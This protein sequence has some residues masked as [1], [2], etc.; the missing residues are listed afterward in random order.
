MHLQVEFSKQ[1]LYIMFKEVRRQEALLNDTETIE[2]LLFTAKY[3]FLSVGQTENGYAYGVPISF[4]WNKE[5]NK[6]YF[7]G[8]AN[9]QKLD[10][11][12]ENSKISFCVVGDINVIP[13]RFTTAYESVIAFGTAKI[14]LTDEEK[15]EAMQLVIQKYSSAYQE[16]GEKMVANVIDKIATFSVEIEHWSGKKNV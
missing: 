5:A 1:L 13:E 16:K 11:L 12:K 3:G 2:N 8:A 7:H 15:K 14:A 9:G 4:V 6:L 10:I